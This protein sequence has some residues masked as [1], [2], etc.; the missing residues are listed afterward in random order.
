MWID[1]IYICKYVAPAAVHAYRVNHSPARCTESTNLF[2]TSYELSNKLCR[3]E[4]HI[5][6]REQVSYPTWRGVKINKQG[7]S[8]NPNK[9]KNLLPITPLIG[10]SIEVV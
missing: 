8:E 7:Y 1:S 10:I 2:P 9:E 3:K 6:D 5:S 4:Y